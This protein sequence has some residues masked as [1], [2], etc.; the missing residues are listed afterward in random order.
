MR[1]DGAR[2]TPTRGLKGLGGLFDVRSPAQPRFGGASFRP[3]L[4]RTGNT[5]PA[6]CTMAAMGAVAAGAILVALL[7]AIT[8][9]MIWQEAGSR[10]RSE[11]TLYLMDEAIAFVHGGLPPANAVRIGRDEVRLILEWSMYH[12]QVVA[13]RRSD[14]SPVIGGPDAAGFVLEQAGLHGRALELKDVEMVL[15]LEAAYLVSI[16]AIGGPVEEAV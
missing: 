4:C 15:E 3:S 7:L 8:A 2:R 1:Q 6:A 16:G 9:A 13:A 10:R 11:E 14:G 5:D 12:S